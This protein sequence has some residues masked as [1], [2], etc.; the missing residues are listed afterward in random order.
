[1]REG[2][3][4]VHATEGVWGFACDPANEDAVRRVLSIKGRQA[5]K[6]LIVIGASADDFAQQLA[7]VDQTHRNRV[8]ES[9]PGRHTWILPD[10]EYPDWVT[11]GHGTL[12]CRVPDHDQ[13]R[14][15]AASVGRPIVS[16]S[17][18]R[19]GEAPVITQEEATCQFAGCVDLIVPGEVGTASGPSVLHGL[20][21]QV[22]RA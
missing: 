20:D 8:T 6:G 17:A 11:G 18:N 21:G 22:L 3:V 13:A 7:K 5:D 10:S 16:T 12:A 2:G 4:I 9:W 1:V 14:A 19:S 15:I